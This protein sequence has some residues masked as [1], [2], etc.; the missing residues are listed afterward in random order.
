M[1]QQAILSNLEGM[2]DLN[3]NGVGPLQ[4]INQGC[5][6]LRPNTIMS[7]DQ[8]QTLDKRV[9]K[10][11][12]EPLVGMADLIAEGLTI[13]NVTET[14]ALGTTE[15][16]YETQG[17]MT[18]AAISMDGASD[19]DPGDKLVRARIITPI[20]I[21]FKDFNLNV[22]FMAAANNHQGRGVASALD[23]SYAEEAARQ[24][25]IAH[26]KL[27]F[28]GSKS[29]IFNNNKVTLFSG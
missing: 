7:E 22:R 24:V 19:T 29:P 3:V 28:R 27:L 26:E 15:W 16:A 13:P 8:W 6:V 12:Q 21:T 11:G 5:Q 10:A 20:P 9:V 14:S 2:G 18:A 25:S 1:T 23:I 4:F 17:V